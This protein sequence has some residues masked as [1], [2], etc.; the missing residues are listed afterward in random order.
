MPIDLATRLLRD[1]HELTADPPGVTRPSFSPAET[2]AHEAVTRAAADLGLEHRTDAGANSYWRLPGRDA[3]APM[4]LFGS[5]LDSNPHGGD[6]DGVIGVLAGLEVQARWLE[7]GERPPFDIVTVAFRGEEIAWFPSPH[8]G[9]K[10]ALGLAGGT[11]VDDLRRSDSGRSLAEHLAEV[12]GDP[13]ALREGVVQVAP[14][15]VRAYVEVHIEQGPVLL[16]EGLPLGLVT[17]IRGC[18][19]WRHGRVLGTHTHAGGVPRHLRRD[20]VL[21]TAEWLHRLEQY[22]IEREAQGADLV[23]TTGIVTTDPAVH[24]LTKVPG[25]MH[26]T[27]DSRSEDPAELDLFAEAA[28]RLATEVGERRGVA[29]DLG[30]ATLA[31]PASLDPGLRATLARLATA[32]GLAHRALPSGGGHD[33]SITS[34]AGI[35]SAMIFVR[36]DKGSHNPD[37]AMDLADL[38]LAV[39]LADALSRELAAMH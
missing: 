24:A 8:L 30:A 3:E 18:R 34:N 28:A 25:A 7:R 9:A 27:L 14:E 19:R 1:I 26:F 10:T 32:R 5:H 29:I 31:A 39:D 37:E 35:P 15:R 13:V 33:C 4:L 6:Y 20:A 36:N 38:A 22:W 16:T 2:Q 17:G 12:G 11:F 21:A 23:M